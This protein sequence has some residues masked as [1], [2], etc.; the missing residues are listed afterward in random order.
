[1][2]STSLPYIVYIDLTDLSGAV[3][4][5]APEHGDGRGRKHGGRK[6]DKNGPT[7]DRSTDGSKRGEGGQGDGTR[8]MRVAAAI[9]AREHFTHAAATDGSRKDARAAESKTA[10]GI[11][12]GADAREAGGTGDTGG[13][14]DLA[15][16]EC[17]EEQER[18]AIAE[19]LEGGRLPDTWEVLDAEM[20]A[21]FR[22]IKR[23]ILESRSKGMD[24][25][26]QRL[27]IL[28]DCSSAIDLR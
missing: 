3:V 18:H 27:L 4:R 1:M 15:L 16:I 5:E 17:S 20:Y 10:Y 6:K 28:T 23:V 25:R 26:E 24:A 9:H 21:I 2:N 13:R 7:R 11:W 12:W 14:E 22:A 19:G 8:V